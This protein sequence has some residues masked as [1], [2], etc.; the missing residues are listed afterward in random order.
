MI[1]ISHRKIDKFTRVLRNYNIHPVHL[2]FYLDQDN[3]PVY[4]PLAELVSEVVSYFPALTDEELLQVATTVDRYWQERVSDDLLLWRDGEALERLA[5]YWLC[6]T[7][8]KEFIDFR[9][10]LRSDYL[11]N[12]VV[13]AA[14]PELRPAHSDEG[15]LQLN[16]PGVVP[17]EDGVFY[18]DHILQCHQFLRRYFTSQPNHDF[19]SR[20]ALYRRKHPDQVVGLAIDHT[21]LV[22][23]DDMLRMVEKDRWYGPPLDWERIDDP[24]AVGLTVH[25]RDVASTLGRWNNIGDPMDRTEFFWSHRNGLK[26]I[27]I[28]EIRAPREDSGHAPDLVINRYVHAMRNIANGAF[29]HLDGAVMIYEGSPYSGRLAANM[30]DEP[31]SSKKVKLFRIDGVIED[32]E[33]SE[34]VALF[35]RQNEMVLEYLNPAYK[36]E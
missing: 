27:Q 22:S 32:S 12:S 36:L 16:M 19:L 4:K 34:L 13:Y 35:F 11:E 33:W 24:N 17:F 23:K 18:R 9:A 21:R 31:K 6:S 20:L 1:P 7:V 10:Y 25:V 28:E 26:T 2:S 8:Q 30:P 29:V 14:F 5:F 15:L 3:H